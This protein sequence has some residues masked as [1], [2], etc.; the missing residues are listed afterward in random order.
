MTPQKVHQNLAQFLFPSN[1]LHIPKKGPKPCFSFA[2]IST[3]FEIISSLDIWGGGAAVPSYRWCQWSPISLFEAGPMPSQAVEVAV[4]AAVCH[5]RAIRTP[6]REVR[7]KQKE[8]GD[9]EVSEYGFVYGS[10]LWKCQSWRTFR[11]FFSFSSFLGGGEKGD[12]LFEN[13]RGGGGYPT[14]G[15]GVVQTG[16]G[17]VSRGGGSG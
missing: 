15:G 13:L 11:I 10:T 14:R 17:R 2:I 3:P 5:T 8:L 9:Q 7:P 16:A 12:F 1:L 4:A 6:T